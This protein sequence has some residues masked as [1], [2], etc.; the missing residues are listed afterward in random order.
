MA[1]KSNHKTVVFTKD[2]AVK[3]VGDEFTCDGMLANSLIQMGVAKYKEVSSE[4][5]SKEEVTVPVKT[6]VKQ[7]SS[8]KKKNK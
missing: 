5:I 4:A 8:S 3:Q 6:E 7:S 2:Y 1:K